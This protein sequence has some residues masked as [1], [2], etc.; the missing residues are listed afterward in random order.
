MSRKDYEI[1]AGVIRAQR[2]DQQSHPCSGVARLSFTE[3]ALADALAQDNPRFDR[4]RF[5]EACRPR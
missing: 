5:R 1:I 2:L 3:W 4:D